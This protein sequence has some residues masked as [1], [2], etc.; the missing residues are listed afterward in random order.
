MFTLLSRFI[1]ES[2]RA[3]RAMIKSL[4]AA[5]PLIR[6]IVLP[7]L[8][9][10][11]WF[12]VN[13]TYHT[14]NKPT[15]VFFPLK[16]TLK[17]HPMETWK[18]Y[19]SL[20]REHAT[21][22]I[23]P[24]F[25]AALAQVESAGNPVAQTY[26]RW[27]LTW[28]PLEWYQPASSA[29]GMFQITDGTFTEAKHYCIHNHK[30]VEDGPWHELQA[31]WFNSLYTRVIPSHAIEL[32]AALLDRQVTE[33]LIGTGRFKTTP[34]HQKQDLAAVLHL[35]GA[36]AGRAYAKGGLRLRP[37]QRCG[38]HNVSAYLARIKALKHRFSKSVASNQII[39]QAH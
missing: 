32:T 21:V 13:W 20:F 9:L 19:E 29:V 10:I 16:D 39:Q 3:V 22:I 34:L 8:L 38:D 25:L 14:V 27:K 2:W 12:G 6:A 7:T 11:L 28:N 18:Q 37:H 5:P 33:L 31:C 26:W 17:K 4:M 1:R 15:E 24:E 23:T 30:A 35:C 36:G